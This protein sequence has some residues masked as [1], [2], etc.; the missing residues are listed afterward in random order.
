MKLD[1]MKLVH[2]LGDPAFYESCPIF[3]DL[4]DGALA[5]YDKYTKLTEEERC[6]K[7]NILVHMSAPLEKLKSRLYELHRDDPQ[8]LKSVRKYLE[9][10][11]EKKTELFTVSIYYDKAV[12]LVSF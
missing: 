10:R 9:R 6:R 7:C 2:M 12:H 8:K 11:L 3:D 5:T 4:K 1:P